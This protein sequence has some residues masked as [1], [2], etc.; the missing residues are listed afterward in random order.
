[1]CCFSPCIEQV[2][3]SCSSL[4]R[5]GF[6]EI[7]TVEC[8]Q[9]MYDTVHERVV[10]QLDVVAGVGESGWTYDNLA[11]REAASSRGGGGVVV[12]RPSPRGEDASTT[13]PTPTTTT[14]TATAPVGEKRSLAEVD[15]EKECGTRKDR[16]GK[17]ARKE[18]GGVRGEGGPLGAKWG[19][20]KSWSV[21]GTSMRFPLEMF[22]KVMVCKPQAAGAKGHTGYL[23]FAR[24][25]LVPVVLKRSGEIVSA[26]ETRHAP[27]GEK[28]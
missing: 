2:Q 15:G 27:K 7:R 23:T 16:K 14:T 26:G 11:R 5:L 21:P 19:G 18:K 3:R 4:A 24:K 28:E 9:R 12:S 17:K 20:E 25:G 13:P 6:E 8:L 10:R 1:M 22:D